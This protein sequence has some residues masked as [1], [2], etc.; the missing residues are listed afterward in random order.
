M[1]GEQSGAAG[2]LKQG[3]RSARRQPVV[4]R[5]L[6]RRH[7]R[8]PARVQWLAPVVAAGAEPPLVVLARARPVVIDLILQ[9]V[10][11]WHGRNHRLCTGS[12]QSSTTH[13]AGLSRRR[14]R[15]EARAKRLLTIRT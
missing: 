13:R 2:K 15:F 6:N 3:A 5:G 4:E 11:A 10:A 12:P 1:A 14:G 9:N 8:S 7:F